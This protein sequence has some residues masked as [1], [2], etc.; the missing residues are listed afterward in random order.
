MRFF[1]RAPIGIGRQTGKKSVDASRLFSNTSIA[2]LIW[3]ASR[4]FETFGPVRDFSFVSAGGM[5]PVVLAW[6]LMV[7]LGKPAIHAPNEQGPPV[8]AD[9]PC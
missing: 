7:G 4:D 2:G 1:M 3:G 8:V 5:S 6:G 9:G